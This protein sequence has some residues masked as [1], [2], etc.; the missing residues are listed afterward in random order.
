MLSL[1]NAYSAVGRNGDAQTLYTESIEQSPDNT[2]YPYELGETYA[3]DGDWE[4]A[5]NIFR[6]LLPRVEENATALGQTLY[7][8]AR[9]LERSGGTAGPAWAALPR[10]S[11]R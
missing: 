10:L 8:L 2:A 6:D 11:W 3:R 9:A 5:A 7:G 4:Q 1:G